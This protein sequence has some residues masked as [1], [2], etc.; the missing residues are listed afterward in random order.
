MDVILSIKR[1]HFENVMDGLK[2]VEIRLTAPKE[3]VERV[4]FHV[5]G[6]SGI[7]GMAR[8]KSINKLFG[9]STAFLQNACIT[10]EELEAYRKDKPFYGWMLTEPERFPAAIP[11]KEFGWERAPQSWGY[12]ESVP[13]GVEG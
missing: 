3:H 9:A 6:V 7:S 10:A 2:I 13:E 5:S 4:F 8:I 1:R 12:A 11:L